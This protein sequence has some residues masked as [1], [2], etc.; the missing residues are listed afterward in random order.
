[1]REPYIFFPFSHISQGQ[2]EAL[3]AFFPSFGF[4]CAAQEKKHHTRLKKL[5]EEDMAI[6]FLPSKDDLYPVDQAF[7]QYLAWARVHKGNEHNLRFLL[8]DNP[9]FTSDLDLTAIK[10]QI[11]G[12]KRT[13]EPAPSEREALHRD[14][15]FL[16]MAEQCDQENESIDSQL[17]GIEKTRGSMFKALLGEKDMIDAPISRGKENMPDPGSMMT[18]ERIQAWS[19]VMMHYKFFPNADKTPLFVTTSKAVMDYLET[20]CSDMINALDIDPIKVHEN[21]CENKIGWQQQVIEE[22]MCAAKG[23]S[24]PL[25]HLPEAKDEC[26]LFGQIKISLFTGNNIHNL[27]NLRDKQIPVCLIRIER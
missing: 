26:S 15:L 1:M 7:E 13:M 14:L 11:R 18:R 10:S 4:F 21:G 22:L 6:P 2:L 8:Q 17:R 19:R 3:E 20:I 12:S 16:K 27:F 5:I 25:K 9:Y 24:G 23:V